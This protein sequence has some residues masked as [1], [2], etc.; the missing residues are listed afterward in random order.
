[1][2]PKEIL[3]QCQAWKKHEFLLSFQV[4]FIPTLQRLWAVSS[5]S[6]TSRLLRAQTDLKVTTRWETA[7]VP[8]S[9]LFKQVHAP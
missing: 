3:M 8:D 1:M 7:S 2:G 9:G 4:G 5:H 6:L